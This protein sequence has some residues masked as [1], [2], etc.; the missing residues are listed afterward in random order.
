MPETPTPTLTDDQ[1]LILNCAASG[2]S[3]AETAAAHGYEPAQVRV[4]LA[5]AMHQL[6]ARSKL[7]AI[8]LAHRRGEIIQPCQTTEEGTHA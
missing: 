3:V 5:G 6:G 1:W 2:M 8:I 4:L 7:E